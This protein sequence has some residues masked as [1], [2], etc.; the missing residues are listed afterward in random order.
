MGGSVRAAGRRNT[1]L[2]SR[3]THRTGMNSHRVVQT[4]AK[5]ALHIMLPDELPELSDEAARALLALI[6]EAVAGKR[7]S[8]ELAA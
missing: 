3:H 4:P 2:G 6:H 7:V 5:P 1:Q 8:R